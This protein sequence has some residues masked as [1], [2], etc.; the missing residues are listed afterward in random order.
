MS[1]QQ[2]LLILAPLLVIN[3]VFVIIA[4]KDLYHRKS[5]LGGNK[6]VWALVILFVNT[7]GWILYFLFGRKENSPNEK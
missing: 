3:L 2:L 1:T 6:V 5:V 4:L 7:I